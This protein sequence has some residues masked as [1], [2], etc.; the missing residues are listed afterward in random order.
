MFNDKKKQNKRRGASFHESAVTILTPGCHFNGK[1]YC[2][3]SSRIGGKV[4]GEIVSEGVLIIEEEATINAAVKADEVI[5]QGKVCGRLHATGRVE[6]TQS[7]QFEGDII[8]PS[9]VICEGAQF[10]G[11]T[12]MSVAEPIHTTKTPSIE[13]I[14]KKGASANSHDISI[15]P[16]PDINASQFPSR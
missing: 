13:K 5:I 11:H 16:V 12:T 8:T 10:N 1:L 6:L 15:K 4:E 2:R 14:G 7:S 9:L 3:G